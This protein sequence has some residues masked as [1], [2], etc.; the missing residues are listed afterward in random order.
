MASP[1]YEERLDVV[2]AGIACLNDKPI[3]CFNGNVVLAVFGG[4]TVAEYCAD[5]VKGAT[6]ALETIKRLEEDAGT[7]YAMNAFPGAM[8]MVVGITFAWNSRVK[9]PGVEI[10][11][12]SIWQVM[13]E[14]LIEPDAYDEIMAIGYNNFLAT[15]IFPRIIDLEYMGKY[16][17]IAG[18]GQPVVDALYANLGI[19][20]F[21]GAPATAVP[22]DPLCGMRSLQGF[23][24]D[25]YKI[26]DKL[27]EVSDFIFNENYAITEKNW[28]TFNNPMALGGWV[29]GWRS[30]SGMVSPKI[31]ETLVWPYMKV[32]AEQMISHNH[33]A[34]M[35]IDSDWTRD[36]ERFGEL[37]EGK[38]VLNTDYMTDLA[39]ARQKV[40]KAAYIGDVPTSMLTTGSPAQV[41]D[42][43]N[44]LI[45]ATGPQGSFIASG[46]DTPISAK[47]ENVV[48]MIKAA[49]EWS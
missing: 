47:Y 28:E 14:A 46:C 39:V 33:I 5:P 22:F 4:M 45:D 16:L 2:K 32:S 38:F 18:E 44:R 31:W 9:I 49:N 21:Q 10:S 25:C 37:P 40:P 1:T 35:H 26:L 15:K 43:V 30:A 27:K 13:E 19:P 34:V 7:I 48:A 24:R 17:H 36:I 8:N 12:D 20:L 11:E 6:L 41:T 3:S 29:G 42:Y 23:Y